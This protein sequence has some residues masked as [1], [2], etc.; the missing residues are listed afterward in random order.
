MDQVE[1]MDYRASGKVIFGATGPLPPQSPK[2]YGLTSFASLMR[3]ER[4]F[5][6][7]M[8]LS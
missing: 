7:Q 8:E 6:R 3:V 1:K 2:T 4:L 5:I